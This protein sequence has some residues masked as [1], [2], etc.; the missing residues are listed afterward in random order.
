MRCKREVVK[1]KRAFPNSRP[2]LQEGV[3]QD[4]TFEEGAELRLLTQ[5]YVGVPH[6][7]GSESRRHGV[8]WSNEESMDNPRRESLGQ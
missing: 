5:D 1:R 4:A 6:S 3:G 8:L 7:G 2:Q